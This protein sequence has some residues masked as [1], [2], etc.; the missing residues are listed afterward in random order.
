[1][2][3]NEPSQSPD[4]K[5]P[6]VS[7]DEAEIARLRA[8]VTARMTSN[9]QRA[10][11]N[12]AAQQQQQQQLY[13]PQ[14]DSLAPVVSRSSTSGQVPRRP[15]PIKEEH[16]TVSPLT[17]AF[18]SPLATTQTA[19]TESTSSSSRTIRGSAAATPAA[20]PLRTPSYPFPY[21]PGT[22]RTWSSSFHQ[23]FTALSPTVSAAQ[24]GDSSTPGGA[25]MSGATTPAAT[26]AAFA[27]QGFEFGP[28]QD[29]RFPTPNVYDLVLQLNSEPGLEAWWST[30]ANIM[31]DVYKADRASLALPADSN[32][33]EN[34][35]WGQKTTFNAAGR[36]D[37]SNG[38]QASNQAPP[39]PIVSLPPRSTP[40]PSP[41]NRIRPNLESRH[42][43]AGHTSAD[44]PQRPGSTLRPNLL[45]RTLSHA[46]SLTN[47]PMPSP[48]LDH[49]THHNYRSTSISEP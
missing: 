49:R 48:G 5:A 27:P 24:S 16:G 40:D 37:D 6:S 43:Y 3:I 39:P 10:K 12:L 34:V 11:A 47:P 35:P 45:S 22:P 26:G 46:P 7:P 33:I 25:P 38:S 18:S 20:M 36:E 23:P 14:P 19:S 32:D 13:Q 29:P 30:V 4:T 28:N 41:L 44:T 21:V 1:P 15:S 9:L 2:T 17:A 8:A 31:N 42:S